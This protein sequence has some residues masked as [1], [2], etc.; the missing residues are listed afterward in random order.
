METV[1]KKNSAI[2]R[3]FLNDRFILLLIIVNSFT[4]FGEGF[5]EFGK[6]ILYYITLVDSLITILF[7]I[8]AIVKITHFGWKAYISSAWNKLDF[9]LVLLSLPSIVL[10]A[11]HSESHGLS[12]LL[13]FRVF[14]VFKFFRLF[15]FI[16]GIDALIKGLQRALKASVFALFGF[17]L[18]NFII[19]IFSH[20]LFKDLSPIHFGDPMRAMYSTFKVF[21]IEGWYEIPDKIAQTSTN[22]NAFA[23]KFYFVLVLIIGGIL[24]L[25]LVNSIFVDSMVMDNNDDLERKVDLLNEKIEILI[26]QQK[27]KLADE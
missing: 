18:L 27:E 12:F 20:Y 11:L 21:T 15:K 3:L 22:F 4:I 1:L 23:I 2:T 8:E 6:N 19:S 14:R 24:G 25:S 26:N 9:I 7:L 17:F 16:P 13:I 5:H 10:L